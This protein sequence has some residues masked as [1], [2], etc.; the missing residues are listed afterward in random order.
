MLGS[1]GFARHQQ[2]PFRQKWTGCGQAEEAA[3]QYI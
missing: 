3:A 2:P 1:G